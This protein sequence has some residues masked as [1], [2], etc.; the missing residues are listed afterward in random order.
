MTNPSVSYNGKQTVTII[1]AGNIG[2]CCAVYLQ[3]QGLDVTVI[4]RVAPGQSC[5]SGSA[6][7]L[8]SWS[9]IPHSVS[10]IASSVP[11]WLLDPDG[12][13][14]IRWRYMPFL[15]PW[16]IKFARSG[17]TGDFK[18]KS[19]ALFALHNPTVG[20]YKELLKTAGAPEL[21]RDSSYLF[22]YRNLNAINPNATSFQMRR[23]RGAKMDFLSGGE[24]QEVEPEIASLYC[25]A[26]AIHE[27]GHTVNPGRL[28]QVLATYFERL[29][30]RVLKDNVQQISHSTDGSVSVVSTL[31]NLTSDYLVIAAGAWSHQLTAQLG[32]KILLETERGYHMTFANPGISIKHTILEDRRQFV[33][34]EMEMGIRSAGTAEFA[35]LNAPPSRRRSAML[36]K[37]GK[38][39]LPN[40]NTDEATNWMG[41]RPVLPDSL[42]AIGAL[43]GHPNV[44][45]AF[46]HGHT[47]LTAAPITGKLVTSMIGN[48]PIDVDAKPFRPDRF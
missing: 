28:V 39:L 11:K 8:S 1:G 6:G 21:I 44:I 4:D 45:A 26:V 10:G 41:H 24:V 35:G 2:M 48:I 33:T 15:M 23:E 17:R 36:A 16:L 9:C 42:P 38:Q 43:P 22:V 5:S 37:I 34:T 29:G 46:G 20:L 30:G 7:V 13:L 25:R 40:L 31:H 3:R 47:G 19:D 18:V 32:C 12:P 14:A 27:Q